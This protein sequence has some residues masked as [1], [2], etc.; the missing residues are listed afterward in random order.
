[1]ASR[2]LIIIAYDIRSPRRLQ[3]ALKLL[4]AHASG[5][6]KSVFECFL[7]RSE[8]RQLIAQLETV[9]AEPDNLL[10]VRH[11]SRRQPITLG[12]ATAPQD[13]PFYYF[14]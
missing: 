4:K 12:I 14:G 7:S 8:R 3:P 6:Q 2:E 11:D 9:L 13:E 10:A 5:R 1:M